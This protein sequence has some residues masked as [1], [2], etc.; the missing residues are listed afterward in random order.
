M[1]L[2]VERFDQRERSEAFRRAIGIDAFPPWLIHGDPDSD[3][4]WDRVRSWFPELQ[5]V[6]V[7]DGE[8]VASAWGVPLRW[9]GAVEDLPHGYTDSLRRAVADREQGVRADALVV[10]AAVVLPGRARTGLAGELLRAMRDLPAAAGLQHVVVPVR[11]TGKVDLPLADIDAYASWTRGDGLPL[12]PWLRTHVRI[13]GRI[14]GTAPASQVLRAPVTVWEAWT[15]AALPASG[16]HVVPGAIA[17]LH[18]D[19]DADLG[20][21]TEGNVWVQHR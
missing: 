11:P 1:T 17:P 13:G 21:M 7:D 6:L 4:Y 9:S 8:P 20:T 19:L 16:D 2:S 3:A 5:I 15:G 18:I 14:L 10:C 12:D